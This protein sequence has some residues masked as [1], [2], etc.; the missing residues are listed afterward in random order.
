MLFMI[1]QHSSPY[2]FAVF[3]AIVLV[4]IRLSVESAWA[5]A[6]SLDTE[7][8]S[9]ALGALAGHSAPYSRVLLQ[10]DGKIIVAA[11]QGGTHMTLRVPEHTDPEPPADEEAQRALF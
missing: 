4:L 1:K 5:Q 2:R 7:F 10:P 9:N 3:L 11:E 8:T 6:V